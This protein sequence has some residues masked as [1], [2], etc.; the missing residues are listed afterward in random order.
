MGSGPATTNP[1]SLEMGQRDEIPLKTVENVGG[2]T[3]QE[4]LSGATEAET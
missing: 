4:R 3:D 1:M 2:E